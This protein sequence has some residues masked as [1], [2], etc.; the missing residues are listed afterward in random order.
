MIHAPTLL[1]SFAPLALALAAALALPAHA[2]PAQAKAQADEARAQADLAKARAELAD[3]ARRVAELSRGLAE[4]DRHLQALRIGGGE[5][6]TP[7]LGVLLG[8][9][10]QS[11]VRIVGVTPGGGADKAGL[12]AGDRLLRIRGQAIAGGTGEARVASAR[13]ALARLEAG[14][15]VPL[16]YQRDGRQHEVAVAPAATQR[17]VFTRSLNRTGGDD[18]I[19]ALDILDSEDLTQLRELGPRLRGEVLRLTRP[20]ACEGDACTAPLLAEAL[21]WD[22]LNLLALEPQL[23]R[24]FGTERG[25]LVLAQGSLP[26]LQAGDVIQSIEG[27]PVATPREAMQAMGGK[28]P[29]EQVRVAVLRD[30]SPRELQVAVPARMRSLDFI[31]APPA[32]PVPP[33]PPRMP[34]PPAPPAAPSAPTVALL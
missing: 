19:A 30:R 12:K 11:G 26:G 2:E 24:Y 33:A 13:E 10:E 18:G 4:E 17:M 3:A 7:R 5:A 21:R 32:P 14:S 23:G 1:R 9:D 16:T 34:A 27:K 6:G 28:K 25:V 22:G 31:P 29:G 20:G 8:V 15:P